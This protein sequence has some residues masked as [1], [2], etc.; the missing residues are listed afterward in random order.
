MHRLF[1]SFLLIL[2]AWGCAGL[3][4]DRLAL[5][6]SSSTYSRGSSLEPEEDPF[7][8][9][10]EPP[11]D[12]SASKPELA[13]V[14]DRGPG[15]PDAPAIAH[16]SS[17]RT[18]ELREFGLAA[19]PVETSPTVP[20]PSAA[21]ARELTTASQELGL[22]PNTPELRPSP[23]AAPKLRQAPSVTFAAAGP[24]P[25]EIVLREPMPAGSSLDTE[26]SPVISRVE[27][28]RDNQVRVAEGRIFETETALVVPALI[29]PQGQ[30]KKANRRSSPEMETYVA[31]LPDLDAPVEIS[32]TGVTVST[33][34]ESHQVQVKV[35]AA[36]TAN[37]TA[38]RPSSLASRGV[39]EQVVATVGTVEVTFT[40]LSEAVKARLAL[41]P[42]TQGSTRR[43]IMNL[44][45]SVLEGLLQR[46][47]IMQEA[48]KCFLAPGQLTELESQIEDRW[49]KHDL[50]RLLKH[51]RAAD[52]AALDLRLASRCFSVNVLRE[53]Y[54]VRELGLELARRDPAASSVEQQDFDAY[55]NLLRKRI[56]IT[57]VMSPAQIAAAAGDPLARGR[58]PGTHLPQE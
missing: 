31:G 44:S 12:H 49:E 4:S 7:A 39:S 45:R 22:S 43:Q 26:P 25:S 13:T 46:A 3:E 14:T 15:A 11:K 42:T 52:S 40:E 29:H 28:V 5:Q 35:P 24:D 21:S 32:A 10:I 58:K 30:V 34:G 48:E 9:I 20:L 27:P 56:P 50:P 38:P 8:K 33:R 1:A 47:L 16:A 51:E 2:M 41:M 6:G 53:R 37:E 23:E 17:E 19:P 55:L 18:A 36:Q 54:A 57:M